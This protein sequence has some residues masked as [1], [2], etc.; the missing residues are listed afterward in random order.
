MEVVHG[1][2][3]C[4]CAERAVLKAPPPPIIVCVCDRGCYGRSELV[5]LVASGLTSAS[6]S[7]TAPASHTE[8]LSCLP[9]ENIIEI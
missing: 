4:V 9:D 7:V 1:V 8:L 2:S 5:S 3:R 6:L